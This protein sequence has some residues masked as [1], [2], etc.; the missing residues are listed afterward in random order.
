MKGFEKVPKGTKTI[1][2]VCVCACVKE[3]SEP[4]EKDEMWFS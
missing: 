3:Q 1:F 4:K 2:L